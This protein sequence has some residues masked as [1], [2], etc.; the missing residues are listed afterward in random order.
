MTGGDENAEVAKVLKF[1]DEVVASLTETYGHLKSGDTD[2]LAKLTPEARAEAHRFRRWALDMRVRTT[3]EQRGSNP[4]E[5]LIAGKLYG[6]PRELIPD[7]EFDTKVLGVMTDKPDFA[8]R[9]SRGLDGPISSSNSS[10]SSS[11]SDSSSDEE[12]SEDEKD[13]AIEDEEAVLVKQTAGLPSAA[14][15]GPPP[16]L[17]AKPMSKLNLTTA[18]IRQKLLQLKKKQQQQKDSA[19]AT[20]SSSTNGKRTRDYESENDDDYQPELKKEFSGQPVVKETE[21][22]NEDDYVPSLC[23][24]NDAVT[25][26]PKTDIDLKN[27][28]D[29]RESSDSSSSGTGSDSNSSDDSDNGNDS[30]RCSSDSSDSE[31]SGKDSDS[32][33]DGSSSSSSSSSGE[34]S[35]YEP[36]ITHLTNRAPPLKQEP[37]SLPDLN[38]QQQQQQQQQQ[39]QVQYQQ[40]HHQYQHQQY[41]PIPF[42][43]QQQSQQYTPYYNPAQLPPAPVPV[44][45]GYAPFQTSQGAGLVPP[46]PGFYAQQQQSLLPSSQFY[47]TQMHHPTTHPKSK[48]FKKQ[49]RYNNRYNKRPPNPNLGPGPSFG[50]DGLSGLY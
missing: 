4:M 10:G 24:N 9:A 26:E 36:T 11:S 7:S 13:N 43:P 14:Q 35:D 34:E 23:S 37:S 17:P 16:N 19:I 29:K 28:S 50:D 31:S 42:N 49:N 15:L 25:K 39:I 22:D 33:N 6:L 27:K 40:Q 3:A 1:R 32:D 20:D 41:Q 18:E 48:P 8:R 30:S 38:Q 2:E 12:E 45:T 21:E 5:R 46:Q 47:Q 44:P